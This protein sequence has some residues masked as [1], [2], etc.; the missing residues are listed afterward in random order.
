MIIVKTQTVR[1]EGVI[2]SIKGVSLLIML[3]HPVS[4][5]ACVVSVVGLFEGRYDLRP[6]GLHLDTILLIWRPRGCVDLEVHTL[7]YP[8][9]VL[10]SGIR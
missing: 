10:V 7:I 2:A 4:L 3:H 6:R 5:S 8:L 1:G 9:P